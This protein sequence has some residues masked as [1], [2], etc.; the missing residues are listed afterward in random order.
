MS[1][2][3]IAAI[4]T[5]L[6]AAAI[7]IIRISGDDALNTAKRV[8]KP[9]SDDK[10]ITAMS[11]YTAAFGHVFDENGEFDEGIVTVF[12]APHSYTG[13]NVAEI[14]LHGGEAVLKRTM[15]ALIKNGARQATAGEFTKRA[16]LNGKMSLTQAESVMDII[17]AEGNDA[18]QCAINVKNGAVYR[19]IHKLC[20]RLTYLQASAVQNIDFPEEGV[21]D[22]DYT[23]LGQGLDEVLCNLNSLIDDFDNGKKIRSGID[24]AIVGRPNV[25]KSTLMNLMSA[26]DRSIVTPIAGTTRD[27]IEE[28][29]EIDGITLRLSDT[30]GIR[31]SGDL[32][33]SIGVDKARERIK[34]AQLVLAV[35]SADEPLCEDDFDVLESI[36]DRPSV[37]ILNKTDLGVGNVMLILEKYGRVI[38]ISAKTGE[39]YDELKAAIISYVGKNRISADSVYLANERQLADA[40]SARDKLNDAI[41]ALKNGLTLDA[42]TVTVESAIES[43]LDL[44]GERASDAVIAQVFEKFCVG[45]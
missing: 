10:D 45:K 7:G 23:A 4:C 25:G 13:E 31:T 9:I 14:S 16:Y 20:D 3:T 17:S 6:T 32:V 12:H 15:R 33:E 19:K 38:P 34:S 43:L 5:P 24:C 36:K 26:A 22:Y 11:G 35:F 27:I 29:V 8:F 42:V 18:L 1:S 39:G 21:D 37:I 30:A 40:V 44:T 2:D 28:T 41:Y